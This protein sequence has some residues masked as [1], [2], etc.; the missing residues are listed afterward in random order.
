MNS[1]EWIPVTE[2]LPKCQLVRDIFKR[3]QQYI[4]D[5]VLV[6]VRSDECDGTHYFVGT[7]IMTGTS[8]EKVDWLMSC[9]YGG[10]AVHHQEI[11]HWMPLP[12]LPKGE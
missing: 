1:N 4:S 9:G 7:D 3:P 10:S 8:L 6:C 2:R 11:T 12:E 5:R